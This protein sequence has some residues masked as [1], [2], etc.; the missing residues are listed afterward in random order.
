[1]SSFDDA[2]R[3]TGIQ[4]KF[5]CGGRPVADDE[6]QLLSLGMQRKRNGEMESGARP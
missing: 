6:R 2:T 1:M 4:A 5:G 3:F